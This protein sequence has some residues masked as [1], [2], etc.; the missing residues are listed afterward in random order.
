MLRR[1]TN[2]HTKCAASYGDDDPDRIHEHNV[3]CDCL[4]FRKYYLP[5][6]HIFLADR[7]Y[8]ILTEDHWNNFVLMFENG[9][10]QEPAREGDRGDI[11][12]PA[13]RALT[14]KE[15]LERL[16]IL[17]EGIDPE[18]REDTLNLWLESLQR[19]S[20]NF[21]TEEGSTYII[22]VERERREAGGE[23]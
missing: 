3:L 17:E 5:C 10:G 7:T 1:P 20:A 21:L 6:R 14:L 8:E 4:F 16:R 19:A 13:R 15:T 12:A 18:E 22:N 2:Y 9:R 11:C 23:E